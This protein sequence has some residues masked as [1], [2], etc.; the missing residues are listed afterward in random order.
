[1][2]LSETT[3]VFPGQGSHQEGMREDVDRE[4][5]D[6]LEAAAEA[7][8]E[9]PF[10][11]LG[12][13]TRF[14]QPAIFCAGLAAYERI[15]RPVPA[16]F[17][18]HSLGELTALVAAGV[19]GEE[20]GLRLVAE[21]GR[22]SDAAAQRAGK[23]GM[24]VLRTCREVASV[25]AERSGLAVAND[26]APEQVVLSGPDAALRAGEQEAEGAGLRAKRLPVAGAFHSSAMR[27]AV[28]GFSA[29]LTQAPLHTGSAPVFSC[30]TRAP[31]D[32]V[33]YRLAQALVSPV[34]W[35]ETLLA[36]SDAGA[37][38]FLEPGPGTILA[39][40]VRRCLPSA[41]VV[42]PDELEPASA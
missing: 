18:G 33:P 36:L 42:R 16:F 12:E 32:D 2:H 1:M 22:L 19:L 34:R 13:G 40:L 8:G 10:A 6:L 30:V 24:I 3:I 41:E 39:G 17:A 15:G 38:R 9:D 23:G 11:R 25:V 37:R 31:F 26:N 14:D 28:P 27:P 4:R 7:V 21:R 5:P 29:A 35:R 20:D